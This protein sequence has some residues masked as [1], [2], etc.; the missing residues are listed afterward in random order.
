MKRHISYVLSLW[1]LL[2]SCLAL[3]GCGNGK[4]PKIQLSEADDTG[5]YTGE[6]IPLGELQES[7]LGYMYTSES[8]LYILADLP[9]TE[10]DGESEEWEVWMYRMD[11]QHPGDFEKVF[12]VA[13]NDEFLPAM[14]CI[15]ETDDF[16]L[17][18]ETRREESEKK[19]YINYF[20]AEG[21]LIKSIDMTEIFPDIDERIIDINAMAVDKEGN[22]YFKSNGRPDEEIV[23]CNADGQKIGTI[24]SNT[25][26]YG[27][28]YDKDMNLYY[29]DSD[30]EEEKTYLKHAE[31]KR[32]ESILLPQKDERIDFVKDTRGGILLRTEQGLWTL[33]ENGA[34]LLVDFAQEGMDNKNVRYICMAPDGSIYMTL[35]GSDIGY[36]PRLYRFTADGQSGD[37][38]NR[39]K[40]CIAGRSIGEDVKIA[41]SAFNMAQDKI[42]VQTEEYGTDEAGEKKL[43]MDITSSDTIDLLC[44]QNRYEMKNPERYLENIYPL[45]AEAGLTDNILDACC[46]RGAETGFFAF[47]GYSL[48][49]MFLLGKQEGDT[50]TL[51]QFRNLLDDSKGKNNVLH[52]TDRYTLFSQ[53]LRANIGEIYRADEKDVDMELLNEIAQ[54]S[55]AA[56]EENR[57]GSL[58][59]HLRSGDCIGA[60]VDLYEPCDYM[61]YLEMMEGKGAYV[62][63]PV[64]EPVTGEEGFSGNTIMPMGGI[65]GVLQQSAHKEEAFEFI[66]YLLGEDYQMKRC[67]PGQIPVSEKGLDRM[68]ETVTADRETVLEDG[69]ELPPYS[70]EVGYEEYSITVDALTAEEEAAFR[71]LLASADRIYEMDGALSEMISEEMEQ[72]FSGKRDLESTDDILKQRI[73]IYLNE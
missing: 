2:M 55:M 3:T 33:T 65:Y 1:V 64:A 29:P 48:H 34:R 26:S 27:F 14:S 71:K 58:P 53:M 42:L 18:M 39:T 50:I 70:I 21:E 28:T 35:W 46:D 43:L 5:I 69:T 52:G 66:R 10:P 17:F 68:M 73:G 56:E 9:V 41:V 37:R 32:I 8:Y 47:P 4:V 6:I 44:V 57:D 45:M 22:Y 40:I 54:T 62:G 16:C 7:S 36:Q 72:Y 60:V 63:L 61:M 23:V 59:S 25:V 20:N 13:G 31:D 38:K 30:K 24:K 12:C 51:K 67:Y 11:L 19:C 49:T 15:P